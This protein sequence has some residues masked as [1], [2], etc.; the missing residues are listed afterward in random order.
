MGPDEAI[1]VKRRRRH[2]S[3]WYVA[4]AVVIVSVLLAL[5]VHRGFIGLAGL[6][7]AIVVARYMFR[8]AWPM[9]TADPPD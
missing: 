4:W 1:P 8:S 9:F 6:V 2:D 7:G 3:F 5:F